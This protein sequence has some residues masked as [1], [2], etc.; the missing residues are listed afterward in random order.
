V[1]A[2]LMKTMRERIGIHWQKGVETGASWPGNNEWLKLCSES[3]SG[4]KGTTKLT[5]SGSSP[6]N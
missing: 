1:I 2:L 4:T 3:P 6:R 5:T